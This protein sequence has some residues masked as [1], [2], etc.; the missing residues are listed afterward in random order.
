MVPL[1]VMTVKHIRQKIKM[2]EDPAAAYKGIDHYQSQK[3]EF[4]LNETIPFPHEFL[5]FNVTAVSSYNYGC[6]KRIKP[7]TG[8]LN[9][10][11]VDF[12]SPMQSG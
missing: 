7:F 10:R 8:L 5:D 12:T 1:R 3:D 9:C 2:F 4:R 6:N 11:M